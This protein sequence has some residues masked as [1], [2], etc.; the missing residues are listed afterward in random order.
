MSCTND[1]C[2]HNPFIFLIP[3]SFFF[4]FFCHRSSSLSLSANAGLSLSHK[5]SRGSPYNCNNNGNLVNIVVH[6]NIYRTLIVRC[7]GPFLLLFFSSRSNVCNTN[8][9]A[10]LIVFTVVGVY[11]IK[12]T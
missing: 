9:L 12:I 2:M 3:D 4:F 8:Y 10:F 11:A 6:M 1:L 5:Q 7:G